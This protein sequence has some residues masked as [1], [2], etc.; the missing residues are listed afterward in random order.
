MAKIWKKMKKS[1]RNGSEESES[2]SSEEDQIKN[3]AKDLVDTSATRKGEAN[4]KSKT[5]LKYFGKIRKGQSPKK[6]AKKTEETKIVKNNKYKSVDKN[7][8]L[9]NQYITKGI[10][11]GQSPKK[12]LKK[13]EK[14]K[15]LKNET[16]LIETKDEIETER[17][18]LNNYE[19][20]EG[21]TSD[22]T[23]LIHG[24]EADWVEE[25]MKGDTAFM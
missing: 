14:N 20:L 23:L 3:K 11:K 24:M 2:E 12:V 9:E 10:K 15:N 5:T 8:G 18:G 21:A 22:T 6:I 13:T 1:L 16:T 17:P 4:H 7:I 19:I 25:E